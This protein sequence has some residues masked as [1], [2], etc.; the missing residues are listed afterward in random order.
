MFNVAELDGIKNLKINQLV[1]V[2]FRSRSEKLRHLKPNFYQAALWQPE[3]SAR[4]G[5]A[6]IPVLVAKPDLAAFKALPADFRAITP[7]VVYGRVRRDP[8]NGY[9]FVRL[10]GNKV[11]LDDAGNATIDW[12]QPPASRPSP[13]APPRR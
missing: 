12:E 11:T 10:Y 7:L 4:R 6:S 8:A 9:T 2:R 5:Y 13:T 1:G 3:R